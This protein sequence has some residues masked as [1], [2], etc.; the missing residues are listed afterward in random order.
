MK[1]RILCFLMSLIMV[2]LIVP[3]SAISISAEEGAAATSVSLKYNGAYPKVGD[4][5][6]YTDADLT[7]EDIFLGE[8]EIDTSNVSNSGIVEWAIAD[9]YSEN[10][11]DYT[12]LEE[13]ASFEEGKCYAVD[14]Y[15]V[16][17]STYRNLMDANTE[18][19]IQFNDGDT[20]AGTVVSANFLYNHVYFFFDMTSA[21]A[22]E[23][24]SIELEA[25]KPE[26]GAAATTPTIKSVNGDE[27]LA[28]K[29]SFMDGRVYWAD[30][31]SLDSSSWGSDWSKV[32]GSFEEGKIYSLHFA[33]QSTITIASSCAVTVSDLDGNVW[34]ED[35]VTVE[36]PYDYLTT[37]AVF[38]TLENAD[39]AST[40]ITSIELSYDGMLPP[41]AGTEVKDFTLVGVNGDANIAN[42]FMNNVDYDFN[43]Y[44]AVNN[45]D[46]GNYYR[47]EKTE[48]I[49]GY[50][51]DA[52]CL[53]KPDEEGKL[54]FGENITYTITH[55]GGVISGDCYS[56]PEEGYFCVDHFFEK[57]AG[58]A[59]P[60]PEKLNITVDGYEV[61]ANVDNL[62]VTFDGEGAIFSEYKVFNIY[63]VQIS[64]DNFESEYMYMIDLYFT[65]A[66]GYSVFGL[67]DVN[68]Q[69]T[70]NGWSV[71][72]SYYLSSTDT[73]VVEAYL[74]M[75]KEGA[76]PLD[77][78]DVTLEG[79]EIGAEAGDVSITF[80]NDAFNIEY[81]YYDGDYWIYYYDENGDSVY[82]YP[83][84]VF[85]Q[86]ITYY[87]RVDVYVDNDYSLNNIG[88]NDI[89][90]NGITPEYAYLEEYWDDDDNLFTEIRFKVALEPFHDHV[91]A[92]NND[93]CD[94]CDAY[95][96]EFTYIYDVNFDFDGYKVGG[97]IGDITV[98]PAEPDKY[99][100]K[101][102]LVYKRS[103][104]TA[105]LCDPNEVIVAGVEYR[106]E[107]KCEAGEIY[108][109]VANFESIHLG[110]FSTSDE[111]ISKLEYKFYLPPL[112]TSTV[113]YPAGE[114]KLGGY[115]KGQTVASLTVE[116]PAG[117]PAGALIY[118]T[119][120]MF[121]TVDGDMVTD[122]GDDVYSLM[123]ALPTNSGYDSM[124]IIDADL[125]LFGAKPNA[126]FYIA[127]KYMLYFDLPS[128]PT[129]TDISV[130]RIDFVLNGY[131]LG[132]NTE[133]VKAVMNSVGC[134]VDASWIVNSITDLS[135]YIE[136]IVAGRKYYL[137][138]SIESL[139]GYSLT[140]INA[141]NVMLGGKAP[142]STF[143]EEGFYVAIF[144]L[145]ALS[146]E[147]SEGESGSE[148]GIESDT[149]SGNE[150]DTDS[151]N[152]SDTESGNESVTDSES[153]NSSKETSSN[154]STTDSEEDGCGSSI[155][156]SAII[157]VVIIGAVL[158]IKKKKI[159]A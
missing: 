103:G 37:D 42:N 134:A 30:V 31:P 135:D 12:T 142:V 106:I 129:L 55:D 102:I 70:V 84:D 68:A 28:D 99:T 19:F 56:Y 44:Y 18:V 17:K 65:G 11:E 128:A 94:V 2:L 8:T 5:I 140:G 67:T 36:S 149:E 143:W 47:Y 150:S 33:I 15:I 109:I 59:I 117:Y 126:I 131:K 63:D 13:G 114:I 69:V 20:K 144:E 86:G 136:T 104:S 72:D 50:F 7:V 64:N 110:G 115:A 119:D 90:L 29:V 147:E 16:S 88:Y 82:L 108:K 155:A 53:F 98:T 57:S 35:D 14:M 71:Y 49:G 116:L 54:S 118:G 139:E 58:E 43:W 97:K 100:V 4:L 48:F 154:A 78:I 148:S 96:G 62:S 81:D 25:A 120:F 133:D 26:V 23:I 159:Y 21:P 124:S 10:Y 38:G 24:T 66:S 34:W 9:E 158:V 138:V 79:Y 45:S 105:V 3:F 123:I 111:D 76:T 95:V 130:D 121:A 132:G 127:G 61:G 80:E 89:K 85:E 40:V 41:V 153:E 87:L 107:I 112:S 39:I 125:T 152:E 137:A 101:S 6:P 73:L 27:A 75:L 151:G 77:G 22:Q 141:S 83:D 74:P 93:R 156:F 146:A 91:D 51:Y 145:D 52:Y 46:S 157:G 32:T 60:S 92:D 1:K 113:S 122:I